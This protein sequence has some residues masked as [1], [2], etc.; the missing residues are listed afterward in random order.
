MKGGNPAI[1]ILDI[2]AAFLIL[3][4]LLAGVYEMIAI[5]NNHISATPDIPYITTIV[6]GWIAQNKMIAL[7]VA[8]LFLAA[9]GWLFFH[10]YL[11][12]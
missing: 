10:F 12:A 5:I 9:I 3:G 2:C 8:M 6:R 4:L 1:I 7:A 11:P